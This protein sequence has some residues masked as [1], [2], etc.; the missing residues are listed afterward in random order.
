MYIPP[1]RPIILRKD[2]DMLKTHNCP[3]YL[4]GEYN[5]NH[6][7]LGDRQNIHPGKQLIG[8]MEIDGSKHPGPD[9]EIFHN[10]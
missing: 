1:R 9:F 7:L 6:R 2:F 3:V 4:L 5:G 10:Q 8:L